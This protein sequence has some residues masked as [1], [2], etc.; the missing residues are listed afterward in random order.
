MKAERG[1]KEHW[2]QQGRLAAGLSNDGY[3]RANGWR[4]RTEGCRCRLQCAGTIGSRR[5]CALAGRPTLVPLRPC[6]R[7]WA[8]ASTWLLGQA[9]AR[10]APGRRKAKMREGATP[11]LHGAADNDQPRFPPQARGAAWPLQRRRSGH[12]Y[13][14]STV[15]ALM[16]VLLG[17]HTHLTR[18]CTGRQNAM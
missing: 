1:G 18:G 6:T 9:R 2:R 10:A 4:R 11:L 7:F 3:A 15:H 8:A 13:T 12:K 16:N 14:R 5:C 17:I